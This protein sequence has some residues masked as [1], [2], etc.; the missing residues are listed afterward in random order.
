[1]NYLTMIVDKYKIILQKASHVEGYEIQTIRSKEGYTGR[2][3]E[4]SD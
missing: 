3:K 1:M 4:I 2:V